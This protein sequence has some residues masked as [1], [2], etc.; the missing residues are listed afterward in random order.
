MLEIYRPSLR[1]AGAIAVLMAWVASLAWLGVRR[2]QTTEESRLSSAASLSLSPG[3]V[4]YALYA[5]TTQVGNASISLDTLSPGY[6]VS[7]TVVLETRDGDSLARSTRLSKI[8]LGTA[9]NVER[10]ESHYSRNG[11]Q[12]EWTMAVLGDTLTARL[13]IGGSIRTYGRSR[14]AE[15]PAASL[16]IPYRL[17]L[18]GGLATGRSREVRMLDGW[19][20]AGGLAQIT[21]GR[22]SVLRFADSSRVGGVAGDWVAVHRD[23]VRAFAV[24]LR[25]AGGPRRI[26]VDHRG[27]VS[28]V[29]TP[30][31]L[32]WVRTDF[33]LSA[34]EFRKTLPGR[35]AAIRG[36]VPD[37]VQFAATSSLRDTATGERRFVVEHRD[38]SPVNLELLALL[39]GGRQSIQSDT[40]TIHRVPELVDGESIR[41]TTPDPMIQSGAGAILRVQR[42]L[43]TAPLDRDRLPALMAAFQALVR[44]DTS[45]SAAGDALGTLSAHAGRPDGIARLFVAI[46]RAS[47]VPS[48]LAIG[49][50]PRGDT[51]L[52]HAWVEI[53][54]TQAGG[55][56]A[57]DPVAGTVAANTGLVRLASGG[58]SHPD[59]MLAL[60]ANARLIDLGRKGTQ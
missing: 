39:A 50:Y 46:L 11:W 18:G 45:A 55:W 52:T 37:L 44:V 30:L 31:G 58:S 2:L 16:T 19:P 51:L 53:W 47:G 35:T 26:W 3:T 29:E 49:V 25:A 56:Y 9:M 57:V 8:W 48:R 28:G 41:D 38:G 13:A 15:A 60:V 43:V 27:A 5:G 4:W 34:T 17:A 14:F 23:S 7:E 54:S 59:E 1:A 20:V 22:D 33:D 6:R 42:T 32:S 36:A 10:L 12:S 21:V 40:V 24:T